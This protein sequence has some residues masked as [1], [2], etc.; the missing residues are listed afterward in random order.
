MA[1][2]KLATCNPYRMSSTK[3]TEPETTDFATSSA[4]LRPVYR[5]Q[6]CSRPKPAIAEM[7]IK[8]SRQAAENNNRRSGKV[9]SNLKNHARLREINIRTAWKAPTNHEFLRRSA[10]ARLMTFIWV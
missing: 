8:M 10:R 1:L 7:R 2:G 6:P 4:S 9:K 3:T 5:H